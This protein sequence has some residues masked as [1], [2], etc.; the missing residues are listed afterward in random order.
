FKGKSPNSCKGL[1]S[2]LL[3]ALKFAWASAFVLLACIAL[4]SCSFG[5]G[6][7]AAE[8]VAP[9]ASPAS[10][11]ASAEPREVV[12][13]DKSHA[14]SIDY[15]MTRQTILGFGASGAWWAQVAG[16]WENAADIVDLLYD[17]EKGIGLNIFRYNIGAGLPSKARDQ[18]RRSHSLEVSPGVYDLSQDESALN[19][20]RLA[21]ERGANRNVLFANSPPARLTVSGFTSGGIEESKPNLAQGS[22]EDFAKY[23]VDIA[24]LLV[25]NG[26]SAEYLSPINEPQWSWGGEGAGQEGCHYKPEQ[27]VSV[28]R[29]VALELEAR[30]IG[31]KLSLAE[32]GKWYDEEYTI[33]LL[34]R[35]LADDAIARSLDHYSV[36]AY[37]S[38]EADRK[39]AAFL[40]SKIPGMLPLYQTEW[41]QMES[42]RDMGMNGAL[43]IA[44][45]I[46]MDMTIMEVS[47]WSYWLGVSFYDYN[48]GLVYADQPSHK[49]KG[50]K[51]LWALGNYSRFVKEGSQRL[52]SS[53]ET[54]D[55]SVSAYQ[56]PDK[57][58]A[59]F[60]VINETDEAQEISVPGIGET[61]VYIT[62]ETRDCVSLHE[63]VGEIW[64]YMLP[65]RSVSTLVGAIK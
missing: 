26:Y 55:L 18:W 65:P 4:S 32:S 49:F 52:Q 34:K 36:H 57:T 51:R 50:A 13:I 28:G 45:E 37:W 7:K 12:A 11:P 1:K 24:E 2:G 30:N 42:N 48:D 54:K 40:F 10:D 39:K 22:E 59:V 35:L 29:A 9:A 46:H 58:E 62:D 23:L 14:L 16:S 63:T 64:G 43:K 41:C 38:T 47:E 8:A 27:V 21:V 15:S 6:K 33:T 44:K 56:S 61:K 19:I 5:E 60:V 31:V 17:K 20:F 53:I 3:R 25:T